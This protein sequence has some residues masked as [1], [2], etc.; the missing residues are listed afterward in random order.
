MNTTKKLGDINFTSKE[1][2]DALKANADGGAES[3]VGLNDDTMDFGR[4]ESFIDES[5]GEKEFNLSITNNT[6]AT[7][8]IQFN[9]IIAAQ[10]GYNILKEGVVATI[11]EGENAKT[12]KANG[13]P[14]S[15]DLL[16]NLIKHA[17]MR[18][19]AIRFNV[20]NE[21]QL[22]EVL[23]Y[24][25]E[26]PFETGVTT[27][28][29]PSN[30]QDQNTNNTKTVTVDL[31]DWVLGHDSTILYTIRAGETVTMTLYFG[32]SF[33]TAKALRKKHDRATKTAATLF[34]RMNKD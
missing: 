5:E 9:E 14:R 30:F 28:K 2:K 17:P 12:L 4:A 8:K 6:A 3:Y 16:A 26:T 21:G 31:K 23:K 24:V 11:G 22:D 29:K 27:Q 19:R 1:L 13:D 20:D 25:R 34:A 10:E 7:Q 33:D 18:L 15:I 32:A